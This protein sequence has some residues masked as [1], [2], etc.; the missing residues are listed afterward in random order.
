[1]LLFV[2]ELLA[3]YSENMGDTF[4]FFGFNPSQTGFTSETIV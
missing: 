4:A 2:F 1:M 3:L